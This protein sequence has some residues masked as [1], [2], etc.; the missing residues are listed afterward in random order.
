MGR[1]KG[2]NLKQQQTVWNHVLFHF[3][4]WEEKVK[5]QPPVGNNVVLDHWY[6]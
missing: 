6:G 3:W 5:L 4:F 1:V 2:R